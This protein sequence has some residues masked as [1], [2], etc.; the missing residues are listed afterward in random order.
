[1]KSSYELREA[2]RNKTLELEIAIETG[3]PHKELLKIY[4]QLKELQFQ[5]VKAELELT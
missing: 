5:L 1:M 2:L 3:R 4:K